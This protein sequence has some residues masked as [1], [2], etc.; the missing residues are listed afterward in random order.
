M[1][2]VLAGAMNVLPVLRG[3]VD[4]VRATFPWMTVT[5]VAGGRA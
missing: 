5:V 4:T 3:S 2:G 1:Q